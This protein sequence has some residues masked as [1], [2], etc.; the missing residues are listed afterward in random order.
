MRSRD[1]LKIK[2]FHITMPT[3]TKLV[4][5]L[6]SLKLDDLM[7]VTLQID[8]IIFPLSQELWPLNLA[9]C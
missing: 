6:Q 3:I 5:L 7:L 1:K 2:I 9:G 4:H 8:K